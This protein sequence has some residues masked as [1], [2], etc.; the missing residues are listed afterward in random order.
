MKPN[1]P[2]WLLRVGKLLL[3]T[4]ISLMLSVGAFAQ[5]DPGNGGDG[6]PGDPDAPIDG[7]VTLLV[8]AGVA[9]GAKQWHNSRKNKKEA[10]S[11]SYN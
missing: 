9:Y 4:G 3:I 1:N 6:N 7:G 11:E 5:G 8:A 10:T 2:N